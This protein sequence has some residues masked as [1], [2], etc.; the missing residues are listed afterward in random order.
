MENRSFCISTVREYDF[1]DA[2]KYLVTEIGDAEKSRRRLYVGVLYDPVAH[3]KREGRDG[4]DAT[5]E[6]HAFRSGNRCCR[7]QETSPPAGAGVRGLAEAAGSDLTDASYAAP[8]PCLQSALCVLLR[9]TEGRRRDDAG[10]CP[11]GAVVRCPTSRTHRTPSSCGIVL[12]GGEPLL[13]KPLIHQILA[14]ARAMQ[15]AGQG[16]FHF[17]MTTNGLLLDEEFLQFAAAN[18]ILIAMSFDGVREAHDHYRRMPDGAPSFDRLLP[19]LRLLLAAA[20]LCQR[21]DG[22]QPGHRAVVD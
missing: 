16:R 3:A 17:K 13:C 20:A 18:D 4:L 7:V 19:K 5:A 14:D 1:K 22:R 10:D 11:A 12:F 8:H 21:A 9:A 15:Q 6:S 2:A